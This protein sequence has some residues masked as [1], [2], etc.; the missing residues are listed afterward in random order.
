MTTT[1]TP[2]RMEVIAQLVHNYAPMADDDTKVNFCIF[3]HEQHAYQSDLS[4]LNLRYEWDA[5]LLTWG[6]TKEN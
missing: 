5:Y 2:T 1:A 6:M 4:E 3:I